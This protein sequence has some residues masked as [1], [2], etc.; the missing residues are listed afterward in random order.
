MDVSRR[1]FSTGS[2]AALAAAWTAGNGVAWAAAPGGPDLLKPDVLRPDVLNPDVLNYVAPELRPTVRKM[3]AAPQIAFSDATLPQIRENAAKALAA[4]AS[5]LAEVPVR[6]QV[7]PVGRGHPDVLVYVINEKPG[8]RRPAIVYMHG[9]G[10]VGGTARQQVS[11]FQSLAA[12]LDCTIVSVEYALAP[13]ARYGTQM[14]QNHA[15]LKWLYTG[16]D[17]LGVDRQRIAVMGE[18]AGG[19]HAA[20][21]ALL[22]RDRG[23][24]PVMFQL[25]VYPALDDRTGSTRR[26]PPVFG[27]VGWNAPSNVFAWRS[28]L[29]M[30]PGGTK[31]PAAAVPARRKDLA[32]LPP[33][34]IGVGGID[35]LAPEN[36]EYARRLLDA[37]VLTDLQVVAGAYHGFDKAAGD[38]GIVK[39]FNAAKVDAF[40]RAF[41]VTTP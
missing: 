41:A 9:G 4:P 13:D 21:L 3:L 39:A 36:I 17:A 10:F 33:A 30:E 12:E 22:A 31:V 29:G 18:S 38:I 40:R 25:L 32:G 26:L 15:A 23:E 28:F 8:T 2:M 24:V 19:C 37:G 5:F 16:A 20:L 6:Q 1:A 14:E 11:R 7:V 35:L 27:A 34:W